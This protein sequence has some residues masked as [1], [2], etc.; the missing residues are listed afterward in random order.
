MTD[1]ASSANASLPSSSP[2]GAPAVLFFSRDIFFA[3][4]VKSAATAAGCQF[5]ILG[6]VD[7][8]VAPEVAQ[9][10][11]ACVVDLTPLDAEQIAQ[12]GRSL[13]ERF[14]GARRIAFGPHVQVDNFAAAAAAGFEP[15]MPKG[16][17]AANLGRLLQ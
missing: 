9:A 2:G 17:V 6:R 14:P 15:V 1:Q 8:T 5:H 10:V 13:S 3:P 4:A 11:R 7:A 12:W 16:Q